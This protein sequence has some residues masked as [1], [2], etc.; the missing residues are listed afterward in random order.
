MVYVLTPK[1][2]ESEE[3]Y[4]ASMYSWT[5]KD[6]Y[7]WGE[8]IGWRYADEP[9][10]TSPEWTPQVG[11]V[12]RLK[13]GGPLMA[14]SGFRFNGDVVCRWFEHFTPHNGTFEFCC[15]EPSTKEDAR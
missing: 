13:S 15:L 12:V 2:G 7:W 14:I 8:I 1:T 10:V 6:Y 5:A 3:P 11:D 9:S 4:K